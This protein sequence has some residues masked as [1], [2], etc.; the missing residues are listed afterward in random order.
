MTHRIFAQFYHDSTC[1]NGKD[2]SGPVKLIP[3]CGSD[4]VFRL[5]LDGRKPLW[6][7]IHDARALARLIPHVKGFRIEAGNYRKSRPLT[8]VIPLTA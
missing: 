7:Q 6:R 1:W 8:N 4:S 2:F 5:D 3:R